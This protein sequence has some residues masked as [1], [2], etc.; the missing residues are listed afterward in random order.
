MLVDE[1]ERDGAD[2]GIGL[3]RQADLPDVA[4]ELGV[5]VEEADQFARC[6]FHP[7]MTPTRNPEILRKRNDARRQFD[8]F[9]RGSVHHHDDVVSTER[10]DG[11]PQPGVAAAHR[12]NHP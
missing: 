8:G 4:A 2:S 9:G 12:E 5:V 11:S 6:R 7:D 10:L 3:E 1:S